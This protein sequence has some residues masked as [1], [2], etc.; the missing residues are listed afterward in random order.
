[1]FDI[2]TTADQQQCPI[3]LLFVGCY[4]AVLRC[5][6]LPRYRTKRWCSDKLKFQGT[7]FR[8]A[9]SWHSREDVRSKSCVS[10]D[11]PVQLAT[12]LPDWSAG[13]LLRNSAARLSVCR[14]VFQIFPIFVARILAR[15]SRG[16]YEENCCRGIPAIVRDMRTVGRRDYCSRGAKLH[17]FNIPVCKIRDRRIL[18]PGRLQHAGS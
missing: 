15:I 13:G 14:V 2:S 11:F 5:G 16:C 17:I 6:R 18:D 8:V 10:G 4:Q 3:S 7:V 12:R 1:M 9:S